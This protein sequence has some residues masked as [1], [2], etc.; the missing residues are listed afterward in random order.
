MDNTKGWILVIGVLALI[1]FA[2]FGMMYMM[3]LQ[4]QR[5]VQP[6]QS[7][8]GDLGTRVA[9][10]LNPTPTILPNPITIIRDVRSLA[11]LETI[12]Y[13]VEK[14]ITAETGQGTLAPLFGDKLIFV[15]HGEVIAGVDMSKLGAD[16]LELRGDTLYV[17]M[18][19][20]E[21]FVATLN[22]EKSY[23]YDRDTGLFT[24]GDVNLE[25]SAR[26][27]AETEIAKAAV[28]D[29][30]LGQARRNAESYLLRLF[31]SLGYKNVEFVGETGAP[32]APVLLTPTP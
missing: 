4:V 26:R 31:G 32:A 7:M 6:V 16:D 1:A 25:S 28:E 14:V 23:V 2:A 15:A 18:P 10:V 19:A 21:I 8:T 13:T 24:H 30:V 17:R 3:Y 11:R 22:N 12:Q 9:S 5:T 20:P 27:V 29:D